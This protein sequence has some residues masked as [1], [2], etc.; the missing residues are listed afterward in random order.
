MDESYRLNMTRQ[1]F[2]GTLLLIN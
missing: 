2:W 1:I